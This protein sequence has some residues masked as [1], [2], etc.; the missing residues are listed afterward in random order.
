L[1]KDDFRERGDRASRN[2]RLCG[3]S[4]LLLRYFENASKIVFKIA[5]KAILKNIV[6]I[7]YR[8]VIESRTVL[9]CK[10]NGTQVGWAFNAFGG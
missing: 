5:F 1:P 7:M 10:G 2:S 6:K 3:V 9:E 8:I 4:E